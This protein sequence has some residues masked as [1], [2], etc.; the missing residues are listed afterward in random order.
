[1]FHLVKKTK[2]TEIFIALILI[3]IGISFR[4]LPHLPNFTPIG[5]IALFGGVY[6]SKKIALAL[7]LIAMVVSDVFIGYYEPGLMAVVYGSFLIYILLGF[8]LKNHKKWYTVI[9]GSLSGSIIFFLL[10]NFAVW[11]FTP[12]Y[13]KTLFGIFECYLLALPFLKNTIIGDLFY[14]GSLFGIY[15][16]ITAFVKRRAAIHLK[17][18]PSRTD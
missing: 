18:I 2:N 9:G 15:E 17:A 7:P 14:A 3:G 11:A 5:A 13:P 1:M 10:T 16:T 12:W 4:F 8:W 6:L